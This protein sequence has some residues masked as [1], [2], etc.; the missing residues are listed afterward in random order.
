MSATNRTAGKDFNE[1]GES[2][3]FV[4]VLKFMPKLSM[5]EMKG[6]I[7]HYPTSI[8][9]GM[10]MLECKEQENGIFYR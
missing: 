10:T 4:E 3:R 7:V 5:K 2:T 6:Q 8:E 9:D 1:F